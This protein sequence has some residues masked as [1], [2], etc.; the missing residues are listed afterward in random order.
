MNYLVTGGAGFIGS[1]LVD[2][3]LE[4]GGKV[5]VIDDFSEG[6]LEN[7]PYGNPDLKIINMSICEPIDFWTK[8]M[9][10]VFHLAALTRPIESLEKPEKYNAVN[11]NGTLGLLV[12]CKNNS[13]KRVVFAS[14]AS[15]YGEQEFFPTSESAF[16]NPMQPYATQKLIGEWYCKLFNNTYALETVM[17]RFFN[18]YGT[19]M[20]PDSPYAA[21]IPIFIK[22]IKAGESPTIYGSGD[23]SRDFIHVDDVVDGIFMASYKDVA[24]QIMNLGSGTNI[25]I[26]NLF[27]LLCRK[28]GVTVDPIYGPAMIEPM[29]TLA[30]RYKALTLMN[31]KSHISLSDGVGRLI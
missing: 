1:H 15:I 14:S 3:L 6:K 23:Q 28:I 5:T 21:V 30:N 22:K 8:G 26:N 10:V 13:V 31:W 12:A 25:S 2:K 7:L 16:P 18:V 19:R 17:L 9:D 29:T 11:V 24:G 20:N 4:Q 27:D